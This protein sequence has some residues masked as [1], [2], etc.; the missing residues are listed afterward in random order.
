MDKID[1]D[2]FKK[3]KLILKTQQRFKTKSRNVFTE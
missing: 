2:I 3:N 1:V